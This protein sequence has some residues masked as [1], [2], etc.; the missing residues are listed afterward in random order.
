[1][2]KLD[3]ASRSALRSEIKSEKGRERMGLFTDSVRNALIREGKLKIH[4]RVMDQV[5]GNYRS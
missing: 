4:Q 2:T 1:M 5:V 3:A